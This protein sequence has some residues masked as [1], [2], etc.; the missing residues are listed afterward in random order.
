MTRSWEMDRTSGN[1]GIA[2]H[3]S[4][5]YAATANPATDLP[6]LHGDTRADVCVIGGGYTGLSAALHLRQCGFDVVLL[7]AERLGW[8][9]SG[10]NGGQVGIGQR[11]PQRELERRLGPD[12][13]H[14][15]WDLA[16][17]SV[18]LVRNLIA[19]H[20]ID[21]DLKTSILHAAWRTSEAAA[22]RAEIEHLQRHYDYGANRCLDRAE[23]S[24]LC[25]SRVFAGGCIEPDSLHLHPLNYAL[26]LAGAAHAAGVRLHEGTRAI[27]YSGDALLRVR[28]AQG[29]VLAEHLVLACNGYLGALEPRIAGLI[30]P[31]NN[32]I[33][34]TEPL[35]EQM[36]RDI[37]PQDLAMQDSRFV[38]DYWRTS[39]DRR[40]LFGGG[41][42]YSS[43]FPA[44]IRALVR[45]RMLEIYPQLAN[46]R[47]DYAWGG[48]LAITR[49]RLPAI[50]RLQRNLY[51]AL[52][53]S[54]HGIST[55][56]MAGKLI[57]EAV[58]GSLEGFDTMARI[59]T[60]RFPGGTLLRHPALVIGMLYYALRDRL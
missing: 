19:A 21:C 20:A 53:Y 43:R 23:V 44:D 14:L 42:N 30:V 12:H 48:T 59:P 51:Y 24:A 6:P 9:A 45:R 3:I 46:A 29:S 17:D 34:A 1:V 5:W 10:R 36:L 55:A 56:T 26:G 16:L 11:K 2:G 60:R 4:S 7:E 38:V 33:I 47:I 52:G 39:T 35:D 22:M 57:A 8:G 40:L 18:A 15:L 25:G 13:A 28:T 54:G 50:G 41:E 32:F 58:R 27:D 37:N 49:S 31:I